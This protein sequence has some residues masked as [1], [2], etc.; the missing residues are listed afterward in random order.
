MSI[1]LIKDLGIY[2]QSLQPKRIR[3]DIKKCDFW[4]FDLQMLVSAGSHQ[5]WDRNRA[6]KNCE[7]DILCLKTETKIWNIW[8]KNQVRREHARKINVSSEINGHLVEMHGQTE[9][10]SHGFE[11]DGPRFFPKVNFWL[12]PNEGQQK[13]Y[14]GRFLI[15]L[16]VCYIS[17][18]NWLSYIEGQMENL[19]FL[20]G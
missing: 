19:T 5:S 12:T 1:Y 17:N 11:H 2:L 8:N 13:G 6:S 7:T 16:T 20:L 14:W 10:E 18:K 15:S 3:Y 4:F 9:K